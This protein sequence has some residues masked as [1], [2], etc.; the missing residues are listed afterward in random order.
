MFDSDRVRASARIEAA[1]A[2][3]IEIRSDIAR[4]AASWDA[5]LLEWTAKVQYDTASGSS[6]AITASLQAL[7]RSLWKKFN[8]GEGSDEAFVAELKALLKA[9]YFALHA[10]KQ[11]GRR[12]CR[13]SDFDP[14]QQRVYGIPGGCMECGQ[15]E[16]APDIERRQ[17]GAPPAE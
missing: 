16:N 7:A 15:L 12:L 4:N 8:L 9:R 6:A 17:E 11:P 5:A 14:R 3:I 2:E 1:T 10:R 13:R